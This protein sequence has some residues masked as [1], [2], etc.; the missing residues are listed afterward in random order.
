MKESRSAIIPLMIG[1]EARATE[2]AAKLRAGG[3]YI[4]AIRYP[5]VARGEARLRLT[6]TAA[7]SSADLAK[8]LAAL[9]TARNNPQPAILRA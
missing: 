2:T 3:I 9:V 4:P 1:A 7:H 5:T 6:L 8:L